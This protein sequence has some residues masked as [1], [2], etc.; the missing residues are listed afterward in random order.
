MWN[1]NKRPWLRPL[2][3]GLLAIVLVLCFFVII[4]LVLNLL[5][6]H[7]G[8]QLFSAPESLSTQES[9]NSES[10]GSSIALARNGE[11]GT[12]DSGDWAATLIELRNQ[13]KSKRADAIAWHSAK[14]GMALHSLDAVQTLDDSTARIRFDSRN[15][16]DL[17]ANSLIVIRRMEQDLLFK[18]K[19]SFMVVVDGELR[20]KLSGDEDGEVYLEVTTPNAVARL[21]T[22]DSDGTPLEFSIRVDDEDQS[23]VTLFSGAAE[24]EAGGESVRLEA[25]QITRIDGNAPPAAPAELP[26]QA[27]LLTPVANAKFFYRD[28]PPRIRFSWDAPPKAER[29]RLQVASDAD[30][31]RLLLDEELT[32]NRFMHGNLTPGTYY[33][34]VSVH[35]AKGE[36]AFSPPRSFRLSKD[37][38]P[39][40]LTVEPLPER[41]ADNSIDIRGH[42]EK[43]AHIYVSGNAIDVAADGSF[44]YRLPLEPGANVIVIE[45]ADDAGN[46]SYS[47]H[48]LTATRGPE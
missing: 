27:T 1:N 42:S 24:V 23:I 9:L 36:G 3:E 2:T 37:R 21:Q 25:N 20:G 39:P 28:L 40:E 11:D 15:E 6:P 10:S 12:F 13:V 48:L 18:E 47:S 34:R 33:W 5:F 43:G 22:G 45:A 38:I 44:R 30:F 4:M 19:R 14:R 16:I 26:K 8:L 46:I 35:D 31:N 7:G 29:F 32:A 17:G 41:T